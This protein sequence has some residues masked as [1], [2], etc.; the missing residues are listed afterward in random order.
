MRP[1]IKIKVPFKQAHLNIGRKQKTTKTYIVE[2]DNDQAGPLYD[3]I[4]HGGDDRL[5]APIASVSVGTAGLKR[6]RKW[7]NAMYAAGCGDRVQSLLVYDCNR[8][9]IELWQSAQ[10]DKTEQITVLPG[11]LPLSEGFLRR[12]EAFQAHYGTIERDL[13]NMVD[14]MSELSHKAGTYPQVILE[15]IGFGGHASLSYLMHSI[16]EAKFPGATFIPIFCLP[17]ERVMERNIREQI[18]EKAQATHG[19]RMSILTDNAVSANDYGQL[20]DRLAIALAA[21]ECA[22]KSTP[23]GGTLAEL[24]GMMGMTKSKWLGVAEHSMP[25]KVEDNKVI[26]GKDENT[27]HAIKAL[28]WN[29]AKPEATQYH[30]ANHSTT[31]LDTEQRI[32]VSLPIQR[33]QLLEIKEDIMDQLRREE[34]D[35]AYP[36]ARVQFAPANYRYRE[37]QGIANAHVSKIFT[38]GEGPQPSLERILNPSYQPTAQRRSLVPTRGQTII[39]AN[40]QPSI[41]GQHNEEAITAG[42]TPE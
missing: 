18:W 36:G 35:A 4:A 19:N 40:R 29:I 1:I 11:Y 42:I 32:Y 41:N 25:I 3:G 20:D 37:R 14:Q 6:S 10:S 2:D 33:D 7:L 12:T 34:F 23:E 5:P 21:V 39:E 22:Y 30:L 38:A 9:S 8:T 31:T 13:E 16:V 27:L 24:A 17:N 15:W 26:V 28:I